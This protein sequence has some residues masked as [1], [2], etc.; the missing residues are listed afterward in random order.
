MAIR[1]FAGAGRTLPRGPGC[2]WLG[3]A[4]DSVSWP[5]STTAASREAEYQDNRRG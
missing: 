5:V 1:R 2:C 4:G 3:A